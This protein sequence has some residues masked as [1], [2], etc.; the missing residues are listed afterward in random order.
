MFLPSEVIALLGLVGFVKLR[1]CES[2]SRCGRGF[3]LKLGDSIG[4]VFLLVV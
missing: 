2:L 3:S 4:G 1:G